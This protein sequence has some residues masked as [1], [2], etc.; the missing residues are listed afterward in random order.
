MTTI[1]IDLG[2]ANTYSNNG[3]SGTQIVK[4]VGLIINNQQNFNHPIELINK[5]MSDFFF[6]RKTNNKDYILTLTFESISTK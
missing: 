3:I 5:P 1:E 6:V 2:Q 4:T